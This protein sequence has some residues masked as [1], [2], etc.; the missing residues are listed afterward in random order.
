MGTYDR[1]TFLKVA[2]GIGATSLTAMAGCSGGGETEEGAEYNAGMVYATGGLGDGSF[3]D[4]AQQGIIQASEDFD[5]AYDEAQP[6]EVA[7]FSD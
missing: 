7:Q 5:L 6:E 3:N 4:Q 1:R 2:G